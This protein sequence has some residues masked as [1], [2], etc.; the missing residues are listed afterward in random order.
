MITMPRMLLIGAAT[1]DAG[2]TTLAY[3]IVHRF[4]ES[5]IVA[6]KATIHRGEEVA[7]HYSVTREEGQ[8][9]EKDT[10]RLFS[11]GAA[12]VYWLRSDER[13]IGK[14]VNEL[15]SLLPAEA[16]VLC[17]SNTL[18]TFVEP[19][20]FLL[21]KRRGESEIK[22]SARAVLPFADRVVESYRAE[23]ELCYTPD[24]A[25]GILF[26]NGSWRFIA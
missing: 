5:G 3:R 25:A 2:K 26:E 6:V 17:E 19:G 4:R 1:R 7:G 21:V 23:E 13:S 11:A 18:R 8:H 24:V 15:L 9:A 10:G 22:P 20:L 12:A 14:A 16:P